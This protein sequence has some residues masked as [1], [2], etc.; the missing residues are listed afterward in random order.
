LSNKD[1]FP[2]TTLNRNSLSLNAS[3]NINPRLISTVNVIYVWEKVHNRVTIGDT[4]GNANTITWLLPGS[5]D[6]TDLKGPNG[7]GS[8]EDGAELRHQPSQF[9][10]NPYWA[11]NHFK[12][13][14]Q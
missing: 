14:D 7:D 5:L 1:I 9:R 12:N 6:I 2:N 4:P 10:T 13:D 8:N 3:A 11:T